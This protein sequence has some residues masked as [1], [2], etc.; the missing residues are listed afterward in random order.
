[1][2]TMAYHDTREAHLE[3]CKNR[4]REY[5]DRG[6]FPNAFTS[7][8]SDLNKHPDWQSGTLIGTMTLLYVIDPSPDNVKRI[9]EGFN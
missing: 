5:M 1:M 3:W 4:A 6:D 9:I 8:M 7:M 2:T